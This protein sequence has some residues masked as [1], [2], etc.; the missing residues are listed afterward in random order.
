MNIYF[1]INSKLVLKITQFFCIFTIL[2]LGSA[3]LLQGR[4]KNQQ[5]IRF[6]TNLIFLARKSLDV[7]SLSQ[8]RYLEK[9]DSA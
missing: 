1:F 7:P 3:E 2:I 8:L 6:G 5:V 9:T 4:E